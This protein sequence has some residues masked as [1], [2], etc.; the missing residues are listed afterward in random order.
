MHEAPTHV[1]DVEL[2]EGLSEVLQSPHDVGH[3]E[4]ITVRPAVNE[5]R[6]LTEAKLTPEGGVDGDR[7]GRDSYYR[8]TDGRSDPRC[9]VSLMNARF[10]RQIAGDEDAMCLAGDNLIMDLDLSEE[11][12]PPSTQ[13]RIGQEVIIEISDKSH[14]GCS[15]FSRRYGDAARTFVN[16]VRGKSLHLRGRYAQIIRGGTIKIGDT[17]TKHGLA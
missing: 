10:L 15:K 6:A 8:L 4:A 1:S 9:Q 7:W 11:N 5:R 17:V 2:Q 12:L 16:S 3:L 13:L 14:T